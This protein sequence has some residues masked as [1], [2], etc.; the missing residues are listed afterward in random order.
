MKKQTVSD[1]Q[2]SNDKLTSYAMKY[3]VAP[4][5]NR[6]GAVHKRNHMKVLHCWVQMN[7]HGRRNYPPLYKV[8]KI[9]PVVLHFNIYLDNLLYFFMYFLIY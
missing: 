1:I 5:K 3:H 6:K 8:N 7:G 9:L 2:R 4:S